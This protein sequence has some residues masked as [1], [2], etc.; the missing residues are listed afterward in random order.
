[1][2]RIPSFSGRP[3]FP[4]GLQVGLEQNCTAEEFSF[5]LRDWSRVE[6]SG[7]SRRCW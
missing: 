2:K 6:Y 7:V 5:P 3:G 1:M 4:N